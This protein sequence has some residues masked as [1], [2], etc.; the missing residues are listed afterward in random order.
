MLGDTTPVPATCQNK[1]D[2]A[3]LALSLF[4][5]VGVVVSYLPQHFRIISAGSSEGFSPWFL[6]LGATSSASGMLNLLIYQWPLFKCCRVV[7][8]GRCLESLLGFIQVTLVWIL[9]SIILILY[10]IYF[11]RHLKYQRTLPLP[12][13][14][15]TTYGAA[16]DEQRVPHP[17]ESNV[18]VERVDGF[19]KPVKARLSTTPEWRLAVTLGAVVAIHLVLLTL[20]SLTLLLTLPPT[21]PPHPLLIYLTT[22]LGVSA[23]M[24]AVLQYGPQIYK[25]YRAGLVGALSLGTMFLQVPGSVLFV[26]SIAL[27]PGTDWTSWMAYAVTGFMQ[28]TLLVICLFWKRR[29]KKLGVD[30]FGSPLDA[31]VADRRTETDRLL[32]ESD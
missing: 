15:P 17:D 9:F 2:P 13:A 28:G 10:L 31:G 6:L 14:P 16:S 1:G 25:T 12:T 21:S 24:L 5:I 22:F 4:L 19:S 8:L 7:S 27:A 30:D 29:Q 18:V 3:T 23:T 26:I 11:P 20:L 32:A